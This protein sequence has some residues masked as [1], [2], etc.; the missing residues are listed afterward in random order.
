MAKKPP[1]IGTLKHRI[2]ITTWADLPDADVGLVRDRTPIAEVWASIEAMKAL[3]VWGWQT[4]VGQRDAP[5]HTIIIR[6]PSDFLVTAEH[7]IFTVTRREEAWFKVI[8]TQPLTDDERFLK[9]M[10]A[11]RT[12]RDARADPATIAVP[13]AD[14][15][16]HEGDM[17]SPAMDA[18]TLTLGVGGPDIGAFVQS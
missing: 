11:K 14:P 15:K 7:W 8:M 18:P 13:S 17:A 9:I 4:D 10:A 5:T 12:F 3:T 16:A 1:I 2:K 6:N